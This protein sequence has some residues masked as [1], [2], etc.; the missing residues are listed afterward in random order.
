MPIHNLLEY[1]NNYSMTSRTFWTY[2]RDEVDDDS[3]KNN[4]AGNYRVNNSKT[5]SKS[6]LSIRE[7]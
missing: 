4:D 2:L 3:N 7:N 6:F 1:I 5:T